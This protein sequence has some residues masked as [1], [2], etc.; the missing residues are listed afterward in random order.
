MTKPNE[1]YA[2]FT[3]TGD[4]NPIDITARLGLS[5]TESWAK[6]DRN[7][8]T[9]YERKFSR[10]S[11][12]SRLGRDA[13]MESQVDDVLEQLQEIKDAVKNVLGE[14]SGGMQ[15]VGHFHRDYPGVHFEV[16][17]LSKLAA[18]NLSL[19]MDFYYMYSDK[20]EDS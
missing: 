12:Y 18:L 19:D 3:V 15:L 13:S 16:S 5:P 17:T 1:Y 14:L 6:G 10:W 20:R 2:Y 7:E 9:H 4:F 8:Q 11:L